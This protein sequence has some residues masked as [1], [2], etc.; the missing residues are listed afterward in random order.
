MVRVA[1]DCCVCGRGEVRAREV[2]AGVGRPSVA[3][4]AAWA[5][6]RDNIIPWQKD[7]VDAGRQAQV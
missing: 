4:A 6:A 7:L 5:K 1:R 2:P 3:A